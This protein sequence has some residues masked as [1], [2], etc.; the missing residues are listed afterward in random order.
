MRE[1][2][3]VNDLISFRGLVYAPLNENGATVAPAR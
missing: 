1:K 3:I 2:S